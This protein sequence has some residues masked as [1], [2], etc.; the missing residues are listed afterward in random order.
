MT[1]HQD[2]L[3]YDTHQNHTHL[4]HK[5]HY[6]TQPNYSGCNKINQNDTKHNAIQYNGAQ[7]PN[8]AA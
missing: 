3:H 4:E 2:I 5:Q 7:H 8:I 1:K 6:D